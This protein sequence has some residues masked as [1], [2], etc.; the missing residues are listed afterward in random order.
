MEKWK[1]CPA[2]HLPMRHPGDYGVVRLAVQK[3]NRWIVA[4]APTL[5]LA[6]FHGWG[7]MVGC[8]AP[9]QN[10]ACRGETFQRLPRGVM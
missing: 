9:D 6:L 4:S 7:L 2:A 1:I 3:I 5:G 8:A 10:I